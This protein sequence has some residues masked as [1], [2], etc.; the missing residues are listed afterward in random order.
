MIKYLYRHS[1]AGSMTGTRV[2]A[3]LMSTNLLF[4]AAAEAKTPGKTYCFRGFCHRVL[5]LAET[6]ADV[7]KTALLST[8]NYDDCKRD[9]FNP[10]GL[11]SSGAVKCFQR[12]PFFGR[13]IVHQRFQL[14][15]AHAR[16]VEHRGTLGNAAASGWRGGVGFSVCNGVFWA[17]VRRT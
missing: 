8:S 13:R 9:R 6:Q 14:G 4:V 2:G 15:R 17:S 1:A 16:T 3:L 10:C 7:G 5:T 11:T 12:M